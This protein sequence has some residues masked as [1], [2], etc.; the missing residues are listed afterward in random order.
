MY[1]IYFIPASDSRKVMSSS[2]IS[3]PTAWLCPV[4]QLAPRTLSWLWPGRLALGKLAILDGDPG[5]GKSLIAL[6]LCARLSTGRPFPDDSTAPG[7][8]SSI[9]LNREDGPED[10]IRARLQGLGADLSRISVLRPQTLG[11]PVFRFPA[12]TAVLRSAI[13]LTHAQ[14]VVIDPIMAFLDGVIA[15]SDQS[16]RSALGPLAQVAEELSCVVLFIRHI[17]KS[18]NLKA[19]YRGGGSIG[20]TGACRSAWLVG[21]DPKDSQRC[22]FAQMKNNLAG[23]QPSLAYRVVHCDN[24]APELSWL[25]PAPCTAEVLLGPRR[26]RAREQAVAFL[27]TFLA[28]G[29][30]TSSD[31]WINACREGVTERTLRRAKKILHV[32]S[33]RV[34]ANGKRLG[35]WLLPG[36]QLPD[37]VSADEDPNSLEPWLAPLRE[38]FPPSTPLDDE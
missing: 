30:C 14:L 10:T 8:G 37:E 1:T 17:N 21:P 6:D 12:H 15:A 25:G 22:I 27:T 5:L 9:V 16:V 26:T 24:A 3:D 2:L 7:V 36:Q 18:T 38:K 28:K 13:A 32:R 33:M 20:I 19:L 31:I 29:P 35:Y 23:P 34:W 11:A 4:S